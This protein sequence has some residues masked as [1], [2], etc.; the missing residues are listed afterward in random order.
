MVKTKRYPS[1]R[2][3]RVK[4]FIAAG[5]FE[6]AEDELKSERKALFQML[7]LNGC[8][9][10]R[11]ELRLTRNSSLLAEC[12]SK[13]NKPLRAKKYFAKALK[14]CERLD[15]PIVRERILRVEAAFYDTKIGRVDAAITTLEG[16]IEKLEA[17]K[18]E[19]EVLT[20]ERMRIEIA[21]TRGLLARCML[22]RDK[23]DDEAIDL[24]LHACRVLRNCG[25]PRYELDILMVWFELKLPA[26]PW[27]KRTLV[28][29]AVVLNGRHVRS[30]DNFVNVS[31][32]VTWVPVASV[33]RNVLARVGF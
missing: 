2:H 21:Y 18:L 8:D 26:S 3:K 4:K 5:L 16:V 25:K 6:Q 11:V 17:L 23:S 27:L 1:P 22:L 29:R 33:S 13:W 28:Q 19:G 30:I 32:Y 9:H 24:L 10:D 31:D 14:H 15:D 20:Q 7:K 12:Y